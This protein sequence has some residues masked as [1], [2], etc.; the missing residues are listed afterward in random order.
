MVRPPTGAVPTV[1][2]LIAAVPAD[3][4]KDGSVNDGDPTATPPVTVATAAVPKA[5]DPTAVV[6]RGAGPESRLSF[7]GAS[8][9]G[10]GRSEMI[11]R[12]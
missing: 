12:S 6:L 5:A 7:R 8:H 4:R 3:R 10:S 11:V 1:S 9:S 2:D